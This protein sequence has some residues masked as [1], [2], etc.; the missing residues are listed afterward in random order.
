MAESKP[1]PAAPSKGDDIGERI[2]RIRKQRALTLVQLSERA[3]VSRAALSKIERGEI[4]PTYLTLRKIALGLE[5]TIA[6]L[7]SISPH[8]AR[9]DIEVVRATENNPF[10]EKYNGYRLLAG[11]AASR[12][13]RCS[14]VDICTQS[15][16]ASEAFHTH[17]TEEIVFVLSGRVICHF[18][19]R[20]PVE[21]NEGDSLFYRGNIPHTFTQA[22]RIRSKKGSNSR[23][24]SLLCIS[25][26]VDPASSDISGGE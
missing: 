24:A 25:M 7:V 20:E 16:P 26:L 22:P 6:G 12:P 17:N 9:T 4:S 14:V 3:G 2:K 21:L 19:G 18:E 5:M 23:P 10:G 13:I 1:P 8:E 11:K 15:L